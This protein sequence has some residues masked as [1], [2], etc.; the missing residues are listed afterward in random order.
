MEPTKDQP[1]KLYNKKIDF[2]KCKCTIRKLNASVKF[3]YVLETIGICTVKQLSS[4][5]EKNLLQKN[6]GKKLLKECILWIKGH[7]VDCQDCKGLI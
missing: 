1:I 3:N 4:H 7:D 6:L 5:S 2:D